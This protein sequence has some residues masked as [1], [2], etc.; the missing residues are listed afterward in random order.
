MHPEDITAFLFPQDVI[1]LGQ[2]SSNLDLRSTFLQ[3]LALTYF[4]STTALKKTQSC[5]KYHVLCIM[6]LCFYVLSWE[7][8]ETANSCPLYYTSTVQCCWDQH[9][10]HSFINYIFIR[11]LL[12]QIIAETHHII[13]PCFQLCSVISMIPQKETLVNTRPYI[14]KKTVIES[15]LFLWALTCFWVYT[16]HASGVIRVTELQK[17]SFSII[18]WNSVPAIQSFEKFSFSADVTKITS[19]ISLTIMCY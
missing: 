12:N 16:A 19:W 17:K 8:L 14:L 18:L 15:I 4:C 1:S 13:S 10:Q 3:S 5:A 6:M 2:G 9:M 11:K 7:Q